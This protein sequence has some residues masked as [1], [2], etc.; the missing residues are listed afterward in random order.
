MAKAGDQIWFIKL[1]G[2]RTVVAAQE[3]AFKTF[4]KSLQFSGSDGAPDGNK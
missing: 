2:D 1:K 3:D 4:L